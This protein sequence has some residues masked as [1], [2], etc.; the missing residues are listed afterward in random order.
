MGE[1]LVI[2]FFAVLALL[3]VPIMLLRINYRVGEVHE[4]QGELSRQVSTQLKVVHDLVVE[5]RRALRQLQ[6]SLQS[7]PG[8]VV[9]EAETRPSP[10][11]VVPD[12]LHPPAPVTAPVAVAVSQPI[13]RPIAER[14]A[15]PIA[16]RISEPA[17]PGVPAATTASE[18]ESAAQPKPV[19]VPAR[20][21]VPA[22][23]CAAGTGCSEC[24]RD[25]SEGCPAQDSQ[26][27][28]GG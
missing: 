15:Q 23:Y 1:F 18:P 9:A 17:T 3:L 25:G 13:A 2:S 14:T 26:L 8:Q 16:E 6:A 27:D 28:R 7:R 19:S 5:Q 11:P 22:Q 12:P 21:H 24:V 4:R 20:F 10:P